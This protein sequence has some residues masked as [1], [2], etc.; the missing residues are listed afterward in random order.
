MQMKLSG[1]ILTWLGG[2]CFPLRRSSKRVPKLYVTLS[3]VTLPAQK[4]KTPIILEPKVTNTEDVTFHQIQQNS[5][6]SISSPEILSTDEVMY[7]KLR[8]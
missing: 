5:I 2:I 8:Y 4:Q 6:F 1:R 3:G 7:M